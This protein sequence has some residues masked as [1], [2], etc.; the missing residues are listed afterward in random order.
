MSDEMI[1]IPRSEYDQLLI[2]ISE[3]QAHIHRLEEEIALLKSG[4]KSGTS[5]TPPSH[6]IGRSNVHSLREK[7][8]RKSGGQFGHKGNSLQLSATPDQII[9]HASDYC[10][11]CGSDLRHT[12]S[13]LSS[14]RQ[15]VDLPA[16]YPAVIEHRSYT[17]TCPHCHYV[18]QCSFPTGVHSPVQYGPNVEG[19]AAYM[20]VYQAIPYRRM[21]HMF[22]DMF[23]LHLSEGSIDNLLEKTGRKAT[24]AY[25]VIQAGISRSGVVGSDETGCRVNG[26]KYWFHVWQSPTLTFIVSVAS[27][28]FKVI[29]KYFT[30]GFPHAVYVSDCWAAQL[31]T[32]AKA[33][34]LCLAHLL[35]ETA[36]FVESLQS[37]WSAQMK[38]VLQRAIKIKG[39]L[40]QGDYL[41]PP[42][43]VIEINREL[44]ELLEVDYSNFHKREQ[45]FIKRLIKHRQ[46]I[47][48]FLTYPDVPPDNNASERAIRNVKT[49]TKVSGQFRNAEGKGADRYAK[50]RSVIDTAIKNGQDV[51]AAL[52]ALA[53][54]PKTVETS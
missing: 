45:A 35:R 28:G 23:G 44:D 33:H 40:G 9:D 34:Q 7:S 32:K 20:S 25:D 11:H 51:Y 14:R 17:R 50:I 47:F 13:N 36:S 15:V 37:Q 10:N 26:K 49:K 43:E 27:R 30:D 8:H 46:S 16:V 42:E 3:L 21:K 18:N 6:D 12:D 29:G 5:S 41:K 2:C 38:D 24:L 31:K 22:R 19:M 54:C 53:K 39:N 48:T 4:R 52:I 1:T